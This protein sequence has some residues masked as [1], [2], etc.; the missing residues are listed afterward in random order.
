M[1]NLQI[2]IIHAMR[3]EVSRSDVSAAI[4]AAWVW[5]IPAGAWTEQ[6]QASRTPGLKRQELCTECPLFHV[7]IGQ[8]GHIAVP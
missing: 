4:W 3:M 7:Q 1:E 5:D 6:A 8:L 2:Y